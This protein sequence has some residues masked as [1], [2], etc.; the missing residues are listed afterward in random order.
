[1]CEVCEAFFHLSSYVAKDMIIVGSTVM[2]FSV[3]FPIDRSEV[4][5]AVAE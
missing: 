3:A 1:M 2:I 4:A 5:G